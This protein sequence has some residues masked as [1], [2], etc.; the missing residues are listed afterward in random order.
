[1]KSPVELYVDELKKKARIL[2]SRS[3]KAL[4]LSRK[5]ETE[6]RRLEEQAVV[7]LKK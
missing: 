1:M 2:R 4:N 3:T 7:L 6:A 5:L